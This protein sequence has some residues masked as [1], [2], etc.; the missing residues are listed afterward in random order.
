VGMIKGTA[1]THKEI[2]E[3]L[4]VTMPDFQSDL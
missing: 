2:F 3:N 1:K 4:D